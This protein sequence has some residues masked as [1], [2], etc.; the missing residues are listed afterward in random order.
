MNVFQAV[1][2]SRIPQTRILLFSLSMA[3]D[4]LWVIV[5]TLSNLLQ[6]GFKESIREETM[7][8]ISQSFKLVFTGRWFKRFLRDEIMPLQIICE[9]NA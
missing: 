1:S 3:L 7:F 2:N 5:S 4:A 8:H 6:K 9:V